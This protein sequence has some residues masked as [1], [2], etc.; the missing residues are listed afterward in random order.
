[1]PSQT[2]HLFF[3][4]K[5]FLVDENVYEPSEDSFLFAENLAVEA[6]QRVLEIGTG[7]GILAILAAR[8]ASNVVAVDVNP[9]AV[10]CAMENAV[11]NNVRGKINFIQGDLFSS[12]NE[13]P[14]FDLILFNPP[15][16]PVNTSEAVSWLSQS[17]AGGPTGRQLIDRF[18]SDVPKY[19]RKGGRALLMQS[20]LAGVDETMRVF[21]KYCLP[22]K[23]IAELSLPFFETLVLFEA[24]VEGT[25]H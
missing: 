10:R 13:S 19:L 14:L 22:A 3:D 15:Y 18:I 12:I 7:C 16:L 24:K 1:M 11:H 6:G 17:W 8:Q 5:V 4:E 25:L 9:Y 21:L 2:K 20:T 23:V